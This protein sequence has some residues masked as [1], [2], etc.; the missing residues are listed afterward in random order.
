MAR[1]ILSLMV[2]LFTL[3]AGAKIIPQDDPALEKAKASEPV[4]T[5]AQS[6]EA[7]DAEE[8]KNNPTDDRKNQSDVSLFDTQHTQIKPRS[9]YTNTVESAPGSKKSAKT[10]TK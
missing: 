2:L 10:G 5:E 4:E 7:E 6:P 8:S 1:T 9:G 3:A